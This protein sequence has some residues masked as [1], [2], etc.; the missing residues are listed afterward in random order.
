MQKKCFFKKL[1]LLT[2]FT[3]A[4]LNVFCQDKLL[5]M[6]IIYSVPIMRSEIKSSEEKDS[7]EYS[8]IVDKRFWWQ[9]FD[10][11]MEKNEVSYDTIV[12]RFSKALKDNFKREFSIGE[13]KQ[14]IDNNVRKVQFEERWWYDTKTMLIKSEVTAFQ[15][16]VTVD[17]IVFDGD[18]L[19]IKEVFSYPLGWFK[20]GLSNNKKNE[21][22]IIASNIE[23]N[24]PIY[25]PVPYQYYF[26]HLEAEYSLPFLDMLL[27]KAEN[28]EIKTYEM[29]TS[30]ISY[31]KLEV[32]KRMG[33]DELEQIVIEDSLDNVIEKDTV[34]RVRY[35]AEDIEYF[36]FGQQWT[37]DLESLTFTKQI[38]YF[39]P[40]I[41]LTTSDNS[42]RGFYPLF[43]IRKD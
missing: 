23:F 8:F 30:T 20:P 6:K 14:L 15:P 26:N 13:T 38:N 16:I 3:I 24:M 29:P 22:I 40:I 42:F 18:E 25:N 28:V 27:A 4:S 37:F 41:L 7:I 12:S 1:I 9:T 36:R 11:V 39:A 34:I 17:S 31:S 10:K 2:F 33:H 43:Y 19:V 21:K 32:V 5:S 35:N